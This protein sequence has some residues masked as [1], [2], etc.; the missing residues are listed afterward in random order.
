MSA[1]AA[2]RAGFVETSGTVSPFDEHPRDL[3]VCNTRIEDY[4]AHELETAGIEH[5]SGDLR[6]LEGPCVVFD[7][8]VVFTAPL[9]EA[10]LE[11]A[12]EAGVPSQCVIP[13]G[14]LTERTVT[15]TMDLAAYDGAFGYRLFY[16]PDCYD[17]DADPRPVRVDAVDFVH[18]LQFPQHMVPGGVYPVPIT[19]KIIVQ[20]KHWANLWSANVGLALAPIAELMDD[21]RSQIRLALAAVSTNQWHVARG[22]VTI[23]TDCDIHPSAYLENAVIG[24]GVEIGAGCVVR[25]STIGSG[26]VLQNNVTVAY[27]VVGEEC[28]LQ[29]NT[30]VSYSLLFDGVFSS[31]QFLNCCVLGRDT[32]VGAGT[33][34]TDFRFDGETVVVLQDGEPVESGQI[35]LGS[36]LGHGSYL[37]AGL[38]VAPGREIPNGVRVTPPP[39]RVVSNLANQSEDIQYVSPD[40]ASANPRE[41]GPPNSPEFR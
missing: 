24:D 36:C 3:P 30:S 13:E 19:T 40:A 16:Y 7:E 12:R 39:D 4:R 21:R 6:E 41:D 26:T 33:V 37:G 18:E 22:N 2:V 23:G 35:F 25:G 38:V 1:S 31:C 28:H 5:V 32:F 17:P 9:L 8:D 14:A 20:V 29:Q 34:Q 11:R 15:Q 27:S 10:F